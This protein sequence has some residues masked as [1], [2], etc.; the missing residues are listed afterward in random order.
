M[1]QLPYESSVQ[2][3]VCLALHDKA[4]RER[5]DREERDRLQRKITFPELLTDICK[6]FATM[7]EKVL[8]KQRKPHV[9][10]TC[11]AIF[12]YAAS[13]KIVNNPRLI[14]EFLKLERTTA[15]YHRDTVQGYLEKQDPQFMGEWWVYLTN[16]ELFNH[17]DFT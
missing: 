1:R 4:E 3:L 5:I 7:Q 9:L 16:S 17:G 11:R 15:I 6:V 8:S 10:I 13:R 2:A 12:C 14:A